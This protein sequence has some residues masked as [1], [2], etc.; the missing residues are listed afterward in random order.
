VPASKVEETIWQAGGNLLKAV[1]LFDVFRGEQIGAG[2]KS[3]AYSLTFQ[4]EDKTLRD[5]DA[6]AARARIVRALEANVGGKLRA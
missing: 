2:R 5:K 3:L 4:A 1:Q 6:D